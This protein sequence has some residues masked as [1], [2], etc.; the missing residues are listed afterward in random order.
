MVRI[1]WEEERRRLGVVK[2]LCWQV[3]VRQQQVVGK[4][5]PGVGR[6]QGRVGRGRVVVVEGG[7][8]RVGWVAWGLG[9]VG[10]GWGRV[11][12]VMVG[13]G[14]GWVAVGREVQVGRVGMEVGREVRV[15]PGPRLWR[16]G[17]GRYPRHQRLGPELKLGLPA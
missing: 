1:Q 11:E 2:K 5:Q 9:A 7:Q 13:R 8:V 4:T 10:V 3:V 12:Q 16:R 6:I 17:S 14:L 15:Q